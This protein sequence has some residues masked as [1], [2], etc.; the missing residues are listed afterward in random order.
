MSNRSPFFLRAGSDKRSGQGRGRTC[1]L[2]DS[3]VT[4]SNEPVSGEALSL[5]SG[6]LRIPVITCLSQQTT[7]PTVRG[8]RS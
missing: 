2:W 5:A 8:P 7:S 4:K 1:Q 3:N 6:L